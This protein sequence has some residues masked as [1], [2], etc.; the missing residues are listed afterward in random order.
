MEMESIFLE[1]EKGTKGGF[2]WGSETATGNILSLM[3]ITMKGIGKTVRIAIQC[4]FNLLHQAVDMGM[5]PI[6]ILEQM[7]VTKV[8][9]SKE[10]GKVKEC[11]HLLSE[12]CMKDRS[13]T[14]RRMVLEF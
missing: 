8:S 6:I 9:L 13:R 11:L 5:E 1:M 14:I 7:N 10:V 2:E 4:I 12:M 3:E